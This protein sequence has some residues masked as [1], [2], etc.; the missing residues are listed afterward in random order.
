MFTY[1]KLGSHSPAFQGLTGRDR[2][3]FDQLFAAFEP[4]HTERLQQTLTK[5]DGQPRKVTSLEAVM[6]S[7]PD[8]MGANVQRVSGLLSDPR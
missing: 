6:D 5:R 7:Y 4:A 1:E 2:E 8:L 3:S